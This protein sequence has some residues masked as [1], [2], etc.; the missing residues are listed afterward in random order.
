[1]GK[2][3]TAAGS[4]LHFDRELTLDVDDQNG[5]CQEGEGN[6]MKITFTDSDDFA[7]LSESPTVRYSCHLPDSR[8]ATFPNQQLS[9]V[10]LALAEKHLII[11][12]VNDFVNKIAMIWSK[13]L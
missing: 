12:T 4:V 7:D 9:N 10:V 3:S 1:M 11:C 6:E 8:I 5:L 2:S 13:T